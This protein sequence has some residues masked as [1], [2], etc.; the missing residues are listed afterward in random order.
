MVARRDSLFR[1]RPRPGRAGRS[2]VEPVPRPQRWARA[3]LSA[4]CGVWASA[5]EFPD[6]GLCFRRDAKPGLQPCAERRS[7]PEQGQ[8]DLT[9]GE[10][11]IDALSGHL[12]IA[13]S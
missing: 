5:M 10:V 6:V 2:L 4:G 8:S 1:L 12:L 3:D 11:N 9:R 7:S 13:V